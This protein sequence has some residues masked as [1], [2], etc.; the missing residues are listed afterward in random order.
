MSLFLNLSSNNILVEYIYYDASNPDTIS[1]TNA[2]FYLMENS[3][4]SQRQV[5]NE[6]GKE[7][8][9]SNTRNRSAV[10][11][12]DKNI[13]YALLTTNKIGTVYNDFDSKLT[14]TSSLPLTFSAP[15]G[16]IYD[17]VRLHF[18]QGFSFNDDF[19]GVSLRISALDKKGVKV[20][21]LN[22]IFSYEDSWS[23]L[24]GN[25]FLY[26]LTN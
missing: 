13:N 4:N 17:T 3:H 26:N 21:L 19:N 24:N 14:D 15:E 23:T 7:S 11:I 25:P 2:G 18:I 8:F 20:N 10:N 1:T 22:G 16:V 5:M 6:D 9:T 12:D